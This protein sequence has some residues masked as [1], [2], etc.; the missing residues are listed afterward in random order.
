MMVTTSGDVLY[1]KITRT[2][3]G[4]V[5]HTST[6][7]VTVDAAHVKRVLY[8]PGSGN[9][10]EPTPAPVKTD[11]QAPAVVDI[12]SRDAL[13][14]QGTIA[15]N[16]GDF[17]DAKDNFA[18]ALL[19]DPKSVPAGRG[20]GFAYVHLNDLTKAAKPLEIAAAK[21][22]HPDRSL[23]LAIS[24]SLVN[25]RSAIRAVKY[26][27]TY[28]DDH[29][30]TLD[31]TMLNAL[32]SALAQVPLSPSS[33]DAVKLYAKLN[34]E[35]EATQPGKKRWGI[36]WFNAD[37]VNQKMAAHES[38]QHK[39]DDATT[40]LQSISNELTAAQS[41]LAH[42]ALAGPSHAVKVRILNQKIGDLKQQQI[43]AQHAKDTAATALNSAPGPSFPSTIIINAGDLILDP[44]AAGSAAIVKPE[45]DDR[46]KPIGADMTAM[47]VDHAAFAPDVVPH[48]VRFAAGFAVAPDLVVCPSDPVAKAAGI[49]VQTSDGKRMQASVVRTNQGLGLA[50]LKVEGGHL[51]CLVAASS[52]GG[53]ILTAWGFPQVN[54]FAPAP[55]PI[56]CTGKPPAA[57]TWSLKFQIA[58]RLP[59]GPI[60]QNGSV[61]GIEMADRDS[62][63]TDIPAIP[64]K[65]LQEFLGTDAK[66]ANPSTDGKTAVVQIAAEQ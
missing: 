31:E 8:D 22:D 16:A 9:E 32:G 19:L 28:F 17:K 62:S 40:R 39:L 13:L 58:P 4:Y 1:G 27:K 36:A 65:S 5:V 53:G 54:I 35:M 7:D 24:A 50:L 48:L 57:E 56:S 18:D 25:A 44:A 3:T 46:N 61:V 2:D 20:L 12:R 64:L 6:R 43:D 51:P 49:L 59:G 41:D 63:L 26:I 29:P 38:A 21:I 66:P 11:P 14:K 55:Q 42:A 34:A 33:A 37:E 30:S 60:L 52:M 47:P 10:P 45:P 23:T 15:Y